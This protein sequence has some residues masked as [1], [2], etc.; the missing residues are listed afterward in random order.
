MHRAA[1]QVHCQVDVAL[2]DMSEGRNT[3]A[4]RARRA[5]QATEGVSRCSVV[6]AAPFLWSCCCC[7][8]RDYG[9]YLLYLLQWAGHNC[10]GCSCNYY[11]LLVR[12]VG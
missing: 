4:P 2:I 3:N 9:C 5:F 7:R 11:L 6:S 1:A 8:L 12:P 10:S